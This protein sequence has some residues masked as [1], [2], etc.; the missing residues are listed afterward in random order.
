MSWLSDFE[1]AEARYHED[2]YREY[3]YRISYGE[4]EEPRKVT[5]PC[6]GWDYTVEDDGDE[7]ERVCGACL[8]W[9]ETDTD[10]IKMWMAEGK[11]ADSHYDT[12]IEDVP[13]EM[14]DNMDILID[15][16]KRRG[17]TRAD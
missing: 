4:E 7:T 9:A 8:E 2:Q 10:T 16:I 13:L 3:M 5:C 12:S 14:R 15:M 17:I 11:E 6:C 1:S